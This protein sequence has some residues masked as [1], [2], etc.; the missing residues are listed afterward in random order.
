[1]CTPYTKT[2]RVIALTAYN[3]EIFKWPA[4]IQQISTRNE[5]PVLFC[6]VKMTSKFLIRLHNNDEHGRCTKAIE[7]T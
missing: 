4:S 1:M 5:F 3:L 7:P 2:R 6:T